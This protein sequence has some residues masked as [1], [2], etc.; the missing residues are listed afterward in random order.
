MYTALS[1]ISLCFVH[2]YFLQP[3]QCIFHTATINRRGVSKMEVWSSC[4]FTA[5]TLLGPFG[6][7]PLQLLVLT[8][9]TCYLLQLF[10]APCCFCMCVVFSLLSKASRLAAPLVQVTFHLHLANTCWLLPEIYVQ[11]NQSGA[12]PS[13]ASLSSLCSISFLCLS[14]NWTVH[15]LPSSS[16]YLPAQGLAHYI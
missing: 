4:H 6:C 14:L 13:A 9:L 8:L 15:I 16:V 2:L 3:P 12:H 10:W 1:V 7:S 11:S 5:K